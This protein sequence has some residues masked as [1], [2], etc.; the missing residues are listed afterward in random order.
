MSENTISKEAIVI[1]R[2]L[3][4]PVSLVWQMWTDSEHFK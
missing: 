4:A 3:E 1:K 2:T